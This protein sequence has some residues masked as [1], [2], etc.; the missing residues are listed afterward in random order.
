M[1][2]RELY[3]VDQ[4]WARRGLFRQRSRRRPWTSLLLLLLLGTLALLLGP[5]DL[6][7]LWGAV[8][9]WGPKPPEVITDPAGDRDR[10]PLPPPRLG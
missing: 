2:D 4:R 5:M 7:G 9:T 6:G 1:R 10:L 3:R 8:Q